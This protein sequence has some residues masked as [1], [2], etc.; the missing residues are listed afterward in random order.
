MPLDEITSV[1]EAKQ[2]ADRITF[3]EKRRDEMHAA[4]SA[5]RESSIGRDE[6]LTILGLLDD[7]MAHLSDS[8]SDDQHLLDCWRDDNAPDYRAADRADYLARTGV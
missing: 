2:V 1:E 5:L 4:V 8:I 7:E 6:Q 3:R